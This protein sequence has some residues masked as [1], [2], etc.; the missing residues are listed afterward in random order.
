MLLVDEC[1]QGFNIDMHDGERRAAY[2]RDYARLLNLI[3][4]AF[5]INEGLRL[6]FKQNRTVNFSVYFLTFFLLPRE[7]T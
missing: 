6:H 2:N 1:E 4:Q 5:S 7:E 3:P